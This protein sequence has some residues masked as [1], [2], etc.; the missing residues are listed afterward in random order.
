M[1]V[2]QTFRELLK[3]D[4][5]NY[6]VK[7]TDIEPID[8][9]FPNLPDWHKEEFDERCD[10]L[11]DVTSI[12]FKYKASNYTLLINTGDPDCNDGTFGVL[13][14]ADND[15]IVDLISTGDKETTIKSVRND[16][17]KLNENF[18]T[19]LLRY[20]EYCKVILEK[21]TEFEYLIFKILVENGYALHNID[22]IDDEFNENND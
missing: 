22:D 5:Y 19:K 11:P 3:N 20:L 18:S 2:G 21:N 4:G 8:E 16:D 9:N 13:F 1:P 6:V 12:F 17:T 15:Q 7:Y 10:E 14:D